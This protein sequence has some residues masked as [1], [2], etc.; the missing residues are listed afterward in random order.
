MHTIGGTVLSMNVDGKKL[1][2]QLNDSAK[3]VANFA[4]KM[5]RCV[6]G[7]TREFHEKYLPACKGFRRVE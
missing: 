1:E 6:C 4:R 5:E 2:K 7:H 3:A